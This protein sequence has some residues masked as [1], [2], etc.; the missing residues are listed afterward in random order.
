M[1]NS[2]SAVW[3]GFRSIKGAQRVWLALMGVP[4]MCLAAPAP[5]AP[6]PAVSA[7]LPAFEVASVKTA[8]DPGRVPMFCLTP[9][10]PGER[11]SVVGPRVDI[12]FMSLQ[13]LIVTA[14]GIKP[15]QLSGP[16]WMRS[17]RFDI[18]AKMPDGV[19][20]ERHSQTHPSRKPPD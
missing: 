7:P 5:Q 9:C 16:D 19:S 1:R 14:Y 15:Y 3:R 4:V 18:A 8:L 2:L 10:T 6:K 11:L 20:Q 17:Q 12:R 13:K